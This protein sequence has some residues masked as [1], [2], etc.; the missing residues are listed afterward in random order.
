MHLQTPSLPLCLAH[1]TLFSPVLQQ[2]SGLMNCCMMLMLRMALVAKGAAPIQIKIL[3]MYRGSLTTLQQT[4]V[5]R[6]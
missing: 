4:I 3:E 1:K 2:N 6:L 5:V